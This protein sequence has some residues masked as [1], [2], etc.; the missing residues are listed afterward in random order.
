MISYIDQKYFWSSVRPSSSNFVIRQLRNHR[1]RHL[2]ILKKQYTLS[3]RK[4]QTQ[5]ILH[6]R[7]CKSPEQSI[8]SYIIDCKRQS[9]LNFS[10]RQPQIHQ[11]PGSTKTKLYY[12]LLLQKKEWKFKERSKAERGRV[13]H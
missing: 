7:R 5:V 10:K 4:Y 11:T 2:T 9:H 3:W 12:T 13:I 8:T 1:C 6:M